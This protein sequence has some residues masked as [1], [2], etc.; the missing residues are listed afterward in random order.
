[1]KYLILIITILLCLFILL[2]L[3]AV[4]KAN[5]YSN[6]EEQWVKDYLK[7]IDKERMDD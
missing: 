5:T 7:R 2:L 4:L 3:A 1:M 6:E